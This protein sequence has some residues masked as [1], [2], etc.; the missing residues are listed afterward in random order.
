MG[1]GAEVGWARLAGTFLQPASKLQL[2]GGSTF[3]LVLWPSVKPSINF[4]ERQWT[5]PQTLGAVQR[6]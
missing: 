6:P 1:P 4:V 2:V 5:G 3:M